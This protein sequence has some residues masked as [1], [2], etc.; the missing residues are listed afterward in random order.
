MLAPR[1]SLPVQSFS[2][3]QGL[4]DGLMSS[5]GAE[6]RSVERFILQSSLLSSAAG[7]RITRGSQSRGLFGLR[8]APALWAG[9]WQRAPGL[10]ELGQPSP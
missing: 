8:R 2:S 4:D 6:I 3:G 5:S 1:G 7:G 10:V 9:V